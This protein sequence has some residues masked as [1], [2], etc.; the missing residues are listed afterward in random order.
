MSV[1]L[2]VQIASLGALVVAIWGLI[3]N[4]RVH[5]RQSNA[6]IFLEYTARYER[7]MA[8]YPAGALV[9]RLDTG[10]ALPESSAALSLVVLR[11]LNLSSEEYYLWRKG[12]LSTDVW[13]IWEAELRRMLRSPLLVREWAALRSE[14]ESYPEFV[15]YVDKVQR[16]PE[17]PSHAQ[18]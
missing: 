14:F 3:Q 8:D 7:I 11:Y 6:Q 15:W 2:L 1:E 10:E 12:Y 13:T 17:A 16:E 5:K 18:G 9:A 4:S